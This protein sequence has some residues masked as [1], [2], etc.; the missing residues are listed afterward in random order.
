[1]K[2]SDQVQKLATEC[3][4]PDDQRLQ[5]LICQVAELARTVET[6]TPVAPPS[7]S[8]AIRAAA[9]EWMNTWHGAFATNKEREDALV[10]I[11][12]RWFGKGETEA[13]SEVD[14]AGK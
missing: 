1:M 14:N 4:Y 3:T 13:R 9:R 2:L 6:L 5:V 12:S 10:A 7:A 11:L 8:A